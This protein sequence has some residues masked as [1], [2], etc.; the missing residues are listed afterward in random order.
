MI[1]ENDYR[2]TTGFVGTPYLLHVLSQNGYADIAYTLLLQDR[3]PSWLYSVKKGA[4]TIWEHW[5]SIKEDGSV[6]DPFMN[7]YN[8][9]AYGS[10]ADWVYEVAAGIK[11]VE[12]YPGFEKI[13]F[14]PTPDDRIDWL[15]ASIDTKYGRVESKWFHFDGK[16]R[17]KIVTP[18]PATIYIED[19]TYHVEPGTYLF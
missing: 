2:L 8:H 1:R 13:V 17:Y 9:Y 6:W 14:A 7:S 10:V 11:T 16:I 4:T 15:A 3:F 5:D 12:E 19:K 18:T